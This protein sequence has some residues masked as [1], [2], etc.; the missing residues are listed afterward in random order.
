MGT[1]NAAL[2]PTSF[3]QLLAQTVLFGLGSRKA[4]LRPQLNSNIKTVL[5]AKF[6]PDAAQI[7]Q[8][9]IKAQSKVV[10]AQLKA[11]G[12]TNKGFEDRKQTLLRSFV[13]D[14]G[15]TAYYDLPLHNP[16]TRNT[17]LLSTGAPQAK[18]RE[19]EEFMRS[20]RHDEAYAQELR[21]EMVTKG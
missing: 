1:L 3:G 20:V 6:L 17:E 18:A 5:D 9:A 10:K 7:A 8:E 12:S 15:S 16:T 11:S 21:D 19:W 14:G 2:E 13:M 4:K